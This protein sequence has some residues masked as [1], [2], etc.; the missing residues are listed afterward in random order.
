MLERH[1]WAVM[2]LTMQGSRLQASASPTGAKAHEHG[3][4]EVIAQEDA[5]L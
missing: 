3:R 4:V 5:V 1:P 2:N